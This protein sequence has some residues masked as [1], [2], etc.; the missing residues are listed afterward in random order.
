MDA[1]I[2]MS[3]ANL[4]ACKWWCGNVGVK[5]L[6]RNRHHCFWQVLMLKQ[7][8]CFDKTVFLLLR[9]FRG[10]I[11]YVLSK[12]LQLL[13]YFALLTLL[14]IHCFFRL[15]RAACGPCISNVMWRQFPSNTISASSRCRRYGREQRLHP[16]M[17]WKKSSAHYELYIDFSKR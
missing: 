7:N 8:C 17:L 1:I 12:R 2:V 15:E 5:R 6:M 10:W 13:H 11:F 3:Q 4:S 9:I 16:P 14:K